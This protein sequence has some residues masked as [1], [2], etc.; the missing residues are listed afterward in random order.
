MLDIS[1]PRV[2]LYEDPSR[3]EKIWQAINGKL[4]LSEQGV[5]L[6]NLSTGKVPGRNSL[7]YSL[8]ADLSGGTGNCVVLAERPSMGDLRNQPEV[9]AKV[10]QELTPGP[11][12]IFVSYVTSQAKPKPKEPEHIPGWDPPSFAEE[13][14]SAV[15]AT[16]VSEKVPVDLG[17]ARDF[18]LPDLDQSLD[19]AIAG[20][21]FLKDKKIVLAL[22][23]LGTHVA[24]EPK[25]NSL[26]YDELIGICMVLKQVGEKKV[27]WQGQI[28][29]GGPADDKK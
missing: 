17:P 24:S 19:A 8:G 2:V 1:R 6:I 26:C 29:M 25:A 21:Q 20:F 9:A 12:N 4:Q 13:S 11:S 23:K 27:T 14:V 22:E 7:L 10:K 3:S 28:V 15:K 5:D 16:P 18:K